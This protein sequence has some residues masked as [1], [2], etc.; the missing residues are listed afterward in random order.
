[1]LDTALSVMMVEA[2]DIIIKGAE[3]LAGALKEKALKY[4]LKAKEKGADSEELEKK[5]NEK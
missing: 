2:M 4:W 5:I 1:M 3:G